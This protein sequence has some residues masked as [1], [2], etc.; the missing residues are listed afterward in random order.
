VVDTSGAAIPEVEVK[1][2]AGQLRPSDRGHDQRCLF[3]IAGIRP[4]IYYVILTAGFRKETVRSRQDRSDQRGGIIIK[5]ELSRARRW[6][7]GVPPARANGQREIS[8]TVT[9]DN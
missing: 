8:T 1:S 5:L 4:E 7:V 6:K 9:N 3:S 2:L